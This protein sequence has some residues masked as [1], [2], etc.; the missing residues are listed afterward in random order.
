[1]E[2]TITSILAIFTLLNISACVYFAAKKFNIAYTV[3][4]VVVGMVLAPLALIPA[5]APVFGF[6]LKAS[7]T[8]ELLF[9]IFLPLLI[10]E[11]G[12]SI[13]IR[14]L[15]NNKLPIALFAIVGIVIAAFGSAF[16]LTVVLGAL[17]FQV[18][19]IVALLFTSVIS[20]TD[21]VAVLALFKD[22]GVPKRLSILFEGESLFNDG[23]AVALFVVVLGVATHGYDGAA[24]ISA[25]IATFVIMVVAGVLLGLFAAAT[26]SVVLRATRTNTFVS[27]TLLIISANVVFIVAELVNH[28]KWH[29][30]GVM[31]EISPIIATTVAALFLGNYGRHALLPKV[32]KYVHQAVNHLAFVTNSLVFIMA[33]LLFASTEIAVRELWVP[34]L[35][36]IVVVAVMRAV[37]VY[38]VTSPLYVVAKKQA[39]PSSW[40]VLL[41]WGSLRGAL[42]IIVMMMVPTDLKVAGWSMETSPRDALLAMTIACILFT[43]FVKAP[44]I[45]PMVRKFGLNV[46]VPLA[47]ARA[48]DFAIYTVTT[49]RDSF[50]ATRAQGTI[51]DEHCRGFE[52]D[53]AHRLAAAVKHRED[54]VRAEGQ[55]LFSDSL[56]LTA[57]SIETHTLKQLYV[58]GEINE[59]EYRRLYSKLRLQTACVEEGQSAQIDPEK[60]HDDRDIFDALAEWFAKITR[61]NHIGAHA[62]M[63]DDLQTHR[64]ELIM[65]KRVVHC[66]ENMRDVDGKTPFLPHAEEHIL[67]LYRHQV[68]VRA[69][70]LDTLITDHPDD[71]GPD[72]RHL[73]FRSRQVFVGQAIH[74]LDHVGAISSADHEL[75]HRTIAATQQQ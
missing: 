73:A 58:N 31:F 51:A 19:F 70:Q 18:P 11:S 7:L 65:A 37:T 49:E 33:G 30:G 4:L 21:P 68:Q 46:P 38:A 36:A 57:L 23:T 53:I 52:E 59:S 44:L 1:M 17:G 13:N 67:E 47:Q 62:A 39:I 75:L 41:S 29:A 74:H 54:L 24:T 69:E 55:K 61:T 48:A 8:P 14:D 9:Y 71:L 12:Y 26:L 66:L 43:L 45:G 10:F 72:L 63:V 28:A 50:H 32:D 60:I 40:Q 25:G 27:A 2:L 42:A 3:L 6:L 20:A 15:V 22:F 35:A 5:T 34:M 64:A 56:L 16:L